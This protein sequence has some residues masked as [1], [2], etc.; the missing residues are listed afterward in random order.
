[1]S[2]SPMA[3]TSA[4]SRFTLS[5]TPNSPVTM[6]Q[7]VNDSGQNYNIETKIFWYG[8]GQFVSFYAYSKQI[9][10]KMFQFTIGVGQPLAP[11]LSHIILNSVTSAS[12]DG[13]TGDGSLGF[14]A[15]SNEGFYPATNAGSKFKLKYFRP[16]VLR[17][18]VDGGFEFDFTQITTGLD[19]QPSQSQ[20]SVLYNVPTPEPTG[21]VLILLGVAAL[22]L[23][24]RRRQPLLA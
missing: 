4:E 24:R 16:G 20:A 5:G 21:T 9:A 11:D 3:N 17:D 2:L 10:E 7:S 22:T 14:G 8:G 1:M 12:V 15:I 13:V 18:G 19:G 23:H 6:G